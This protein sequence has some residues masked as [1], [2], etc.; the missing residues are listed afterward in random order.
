MKIMKGDL[1]ILFRSRS[2]QFLKDFSRTSDVLSEIMYDGHTLYYRPGTSDVVV[3]YNILFK[4]GMRSEYWIPK[5]VKPKVILDIGAN[6]GISS[7]NFSRLFPKAKIYAFEPE[8]GNFSLLEK[9]TAQIK[10]VSVFHKA[11][12]A[13]DG[14]REF[15][16]QGYNKCGHSFYDHAEI[17]NK[18][19][20]SVRNADQALRDIGLEWID[21]IKIDTEGAEYEILTTIDRGIL[22]NVKWIVGE[23]HGVRDFELLSYL[24]E[25]FFID[26]RCSMSKNFFRFNACNKFLLDHLGL[27]EKATKSLQK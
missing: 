3:I 13:I 11:L 14:K 20:V 22:K 4:A 9:N 1:E 2:W 16:L 25:F 26:M 27:S 6:I 18:V 19:S 24:S 21:L 15:Y 7:V 17:E 5:K 12:G 8:E 23:L 10:N